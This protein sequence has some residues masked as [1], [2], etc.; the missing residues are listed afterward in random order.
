[1]W[2][3]TSGTW[4]K[5]LMFQVLPTTLWNSDTHVLPL[6]QYVSRFLLVPDSKG[7]PYASQISWGPNSKVKPF[8]RVVG[9]RPTLTIEESSSP[10]LVVMRIMWGAFSKCKCWP[11]PRYGTSRSSATTS[12]SGTRAPPWFQCSYML[13]KKP[14]VLVLNGNPNSLKIIQASR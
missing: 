13:K 4:W 11:H 8:G 12:V 3:E 5:L 6:F 10:T 1:M 2:K 7:S 14:P 9:F